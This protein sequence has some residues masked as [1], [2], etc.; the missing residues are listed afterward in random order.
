MRDRE[1]LESAGSGITHEHR[2]IQ[3][4]VEAF[5][6]RAIHQLVLGISRSTW[7]K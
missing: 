6:S 7:N 3:T 1:P 4:D 2:E 5:A